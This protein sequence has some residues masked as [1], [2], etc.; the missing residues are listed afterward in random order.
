M[1]IFWRGEEPRGGGAG[2]GTDGGAGALW[3]LGVEVEDEI[4]RV[5]RVEGEEDVS[6]FQDYGGFQYFLSYRKV[7]RKF[8]FLVQ[9][10]SHYIQ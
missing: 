9:E 1:I 6:G 10:A 8:K 3:V 5:Q 7:R 4:D 2:G